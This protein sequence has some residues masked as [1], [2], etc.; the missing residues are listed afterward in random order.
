MPDWPRYVR[1]NLSLPGIRPE[2][3]ESIVTDVAQ[4]LED[5]FEEARAR[6]LSETAAE[7][8]ARNHIPDWNFFAEAVCSAQQGAGLGRL[9][10]WQ[11]NHLRNQDL[12]NRSGFLKWLSDLR[13]DFLYG[14]RMLLKRPLMTV[15]A[16]LTLALGIGA[17]SA[18]FSVVQA[19][20]FRP[21]PFPE[22][23]QL[24]MLWE[25]ARKTNHLHNYISPANYY[26]WEERSRSFSEMAALHYSNKTLTGA[27][28]PVRL[29]GA[30]VERSFFQV[31]GN[32]PQLGSFF[33]TGPSAPEDQVVLSSDLW[34]HVFSGSPDVIGRSLLLDGQS[35]L[36]VGVVS[37]RAA[38]PPGSEFWIPWNA[39]R[40]ARG[41]YLMSLARLKPDQTLDQAQAEMTNIGRRLE[42]EHPEFN[43]EFGVFIEPLRDSYSGSFKELVPLLLMALALIL[44]I[45]CANVAG[46]LLS[47]LPTRNREMAIRR[48]LGAEGG[49]LVRQLLVEGSIL[50]LLGG[51][52][53]S[54][55]AYLFLPVLRVLVP[56][57]ITETFQI[58][59]DLPVLLFM[60]AIAG[61]CGFLFGLIPALQVR[62]ADLALSLR[63][64][65]RNVASAGH[66]VRTVLVV[67][68]VSLS[69]V[70]LVSAG[71]LVRSLFRL[72][73]VDPGFRVEDIQTF[74]P[75]LP[76]AAGGER[77]EEGYR[78][79]G[80]F[81]QMLD[82]LASIPDVE[83]VGA[84]NFLPFR[85]GVA[86]SYVILA[87]RP[88]PPPGQAP[89]PDIVSLGG[90][91]FQTLGIPL[92]EGRFFDSG[93]QQQAPTVAIIN[94]AMARQYWPTESPLGH[95]LKMPWDGLLEAEIVGVV[96][97]VRQRNYAADIRPA[98]YWHAPQFPYGFMTVVARTDLGPQAFSGLARDVVS[99]LDPDLPLS[100]IEPLTHYL[101]RS[102]EQT[103]VTLQLLG[104]FAALALILSVVG[105][106]GIL[107]SWVGLRFREIGIRMA[108][109]AGKASLIRL[110]VGRGTVLGLLGLLLGLVGSL[111]ASRLLASKLYQISHTDPVT[112]L[113]VS[114]LILTASLASCYLPARRALEIDPLETLRAE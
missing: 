72:I 28:N 90:D 14:L 19:A 29:S 74:T 68:Q 40:D 69:V 53:G 76:R 73:A 12:G 57:A 22:P 35:Y 58:S 84:V 83:S 9:E 81:Q 102:L 95:K 62:K 71:L 42:Q 50:A 39:P 91:Y 89:S 49:R 97:N 33:E 8:V 5:A 79:A 6:G 16:L 20:L 37:S 2:R 87:D 66:R 63:S 44:L 26:A 48:A 104:A 92:K 67:A 106:Y 98:V 55:V 15:L 77:T 24:V 56:G 100:E 47:R 54:V 13:L 78:Q 107:S 94:E 105:I 3:V 32:Q 99:E 114:I 93:D 27:G 103:R 111:A 31:L 38:F 59:I 112:F 70:L 51:L 46:L 80:F 86:S 1:E 10:R 34:H 41:R 11:E 82:R 4:I 96:G 64:G 21:L 109:G 30:A 17:N 61:L 36:I 18:I 60:L 110:V 88:E 45:A 75:V 108:L 25:H 23:G 43:T 52:A 101:N 65:G 85:A 113:C 7:A